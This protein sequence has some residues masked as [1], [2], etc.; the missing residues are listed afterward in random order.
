M[1]KKYYLFFSHA[2][3]I[4]YSQLKKYGA[5]LGQRQPVSQPMRWLIVLAGF[6]LG[7]VIPVYRPKLETVNK[8]V[9]FR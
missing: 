8:T 1:R 7:K 3:R 9:K 2:S 6:D 4:D 5:W